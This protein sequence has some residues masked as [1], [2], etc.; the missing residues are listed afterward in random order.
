MG[1]IIETPKFND[2][3][4]DN[5]GDTLNKYLSKRRDDDEGDNDDDSRDSRDDRDNQDS[6]SHRSESRNSNSSK[7]NSNEELQKAPTQN[8]GFV[9]FQGQEKPIEQIQQKEE[10]ES[11]F[12][13]PLIKYSIIGLISIIAL[14][15]IIRFIIKRR[16]K[17]DL[18]K[19]FSKN[20]NKVKDIIKLPEAD[21]YSY[22]SKQTSTS[23]GDLYRIES[24]D[25]IVNMFHSTDITYERGSN[26]NFSPI[27]SNNYSSKV[28]SISLI[29]N[30]ATSPIEGDISIASPRSLQNIHLP[31]SSSSSISLS[32]DESKTVLNNSGKRLIQHSSVNIKPQRRSKF[33]TSRSKYLSDSNYYMPP[34]FCMTPLVT[35]N[36]PG[37][38]QSPIPSDDVYEYPPTPLPDSLDDIP[39]SDNPDIESEDTDAVSSIIEQSE[40]VE[41][42]QENKPQRVETQVI[43]PQEIKLQD[44]SNKKSKQRLHTVKKRTAQSTPIKRQPSPLQK[45]ASPYYEEENHNH[46]RLL[47]ES[48]KSSVSMKNKFTYTLEPILP[49]SV[50]QTNKKS[51]I[52][53]P[54][55]KIPIREMK[56]DSI[57]PLQRQPPQLKIQSSQSEISMG[58]HKPQ[59]S[60]KSSPVVVFKNQSTEQSKSKIDSQ[61]ES[62][63]SSKPMMSIQSKSV[64]Q[65][66]SKITAQHQSTK[67]SRWKDDN[68]GQY[69]D[70]SKPKM[71]SKYETFNSSKLKTTTQSEY[72][73]SSKSKVD[74]HYESV[75]SSK[76]KTISQRESLQTS[77]PKMT[78]PREYLLSSKPKITSSRESQQTSKP[79]TISQRESLQSSKQKA[80]SQQESIPSFRSKASSQ[81]EINQPAKPKVTFKRQTI[82]T[83]KPKDS[84][85]QYSQISKPITQPRQYEPSK[86]MVNP[87]SNSLIINRKE[88]QPKS[89]LKNNHN[90]T[91]LF[92]QAFKKVTTK[93]EPRS[94][95][96]RQPKRIS[97]QAP[98]PKPRFSSRD[99]KSSSS[100]MNTNLNEGMSNLSIELPKSPELS[101]EEEMM[102]SF[103]MF[104][105]SLN[106]SFN[107]YNDNVNTQS[108]ILNANHVI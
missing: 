39:F 43:K 8:N 33:V 2:K 88:D 61:L 18:S 47:Q 101:F 59:L 9:G 57:S 86:P 17:S 16:K 10:N 78:S 107:L 3:F 76:S 98:K 6:D 31:S 50:S 93:S 103:D 85:Q 37:L 106:S 41:K 19:N 34:N 23:V 89:I 73:Y 36:I 102:A 65:S 71:T 97:T 56:S 20:Y 66:R 35:K 81:H 22:E 74:P 53:V 24:T 69:L 48:I 95:N 99:V 29:N 82:Q 21:S 40:G 63:H 64:Q 67:Q 58:I 70:S 92:S 94:L 77:K 60:Q 5:E 15:I 80:T 26:W 96:V 30:Q 83:S 52:P 105:D 51:S 108:R 75:Q 68:K 49:P 28:G 72:I 45:E 84:P 11:I 1:I 12:N 90:K 38:D 27:T 87:Q 79:R 46:S 44:T 32:S 91:H 54:T 104:S 42:I 13:E 25:S 7:H 62:I 4:F 55:N 100:N 14:Y